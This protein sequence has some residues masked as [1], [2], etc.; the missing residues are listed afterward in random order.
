MDCITVKNIPYNNYLD[1]NISDFY[2][3]SKYFK[4]LE[5][6]LNYIEMFSGKV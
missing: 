6:T 1:S 2:S 3:I 4:N 5:M